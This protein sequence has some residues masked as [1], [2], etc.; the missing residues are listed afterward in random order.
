MRTHPQNKKNLF[1]MSSIY[2]VAHIMLAQTN[3]IVKTLKLICVD[4]ELIHIQYVIGIECI[5]IL[6]LIIHILLIIRI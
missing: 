1:E 3:K 4:H 5:S 2:V 6:V